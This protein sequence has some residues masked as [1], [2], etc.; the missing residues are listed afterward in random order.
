MLFFFFFAA[1]FAN[2]VTIRRI[3]NHMLL[4]RATKMHDKDGAHYCADVLP[5]KSEKHERGCCSSERVHTCVTHYGIALLAIYE[6][7]HGD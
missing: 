3:T 6:A 1:S 4:S 7:P 2:N 5:Q